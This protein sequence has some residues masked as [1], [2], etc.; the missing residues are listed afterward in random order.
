MTPGT[1]NLS[2]RQG[3]TFARILTI[4]NADP[5]DASGQTPGTPVDLTGCVAEMQIVPSFNA[6][7]PYSLSSV[8]A[9][10]NGGT[11]ILGGAA[12]TVAIDIPAAD[13][14]TLNSGE[15]DLK[16]KFPNGDIMT[17]VEGGV[18]VDQEVTVWM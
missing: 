14:L 4:F 5:A 10:A 11:I 15:Y 6:A 7:R 17:F 13:T 1:L 18:T 2:V 3:D 12:G 16:L 8:A 9:T